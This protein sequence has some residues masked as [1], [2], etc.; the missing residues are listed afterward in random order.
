MP[1]LDDATIPDSTLL[2]RVLAKGW[3]TTKGGTYRVASIAFFEVRGEVSL[4]LDAPGLLEDLRRIFPGREIASVS[5]M[6][7][8]EAGLVIERRPAECPLAGR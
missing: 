1:L 2:F 8:R 3:T 6:V 7:I 5:A 4:F